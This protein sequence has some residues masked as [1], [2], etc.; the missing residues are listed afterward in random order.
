MTSGWSGRRIHA[1]SRA[2]RREQGDRGE[3]D[4]DQLGA[5]P[6]EK[7]GDHFHHPALASAS[8][9]ARV[10]AR[11]A[12]WSTTTRRSTTVTCPPGGPALGRNRAGLRRGLTRKRH[13]DH[14]GLA[15]AVGRSNR[16]GQ[17]CSLSTSVTSRC[18]HGN[19]STPLT[20]WKNSGNSATDSDA[21]IAGP[22]RWP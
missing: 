18:C 10:S 4:L 3:R 9:L 6:A 12:A 22:L 21:F 7:I 1:S 15:G 8:S 2:T 13:V 16:S 11:G 17:R 5:R 14:G 19:G 20:A